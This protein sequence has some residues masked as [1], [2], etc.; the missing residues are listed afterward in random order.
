MKFGTYNPCM[1][2]DSPNFHYD[3]FGG[4]IVIYLLM[5]ATL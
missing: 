3:L 5:F 4:I 2:S 1:F